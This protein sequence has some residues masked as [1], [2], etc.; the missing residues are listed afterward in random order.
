MNVETH[1]P[2]TRERLYS[3][4]R[5][6]V[7]AARDFTRTTLTTWN[8]R[9]PLDDVL[10]CVS[11]LTTNA[12]LYGVPPGRYFLLRLRPHGDAGVRVEVHDSGD[13]T[14]PIVPVPREDGGRGLLLVATLADKWGAERRH[15]GK[16]VWCEFG[17]HRR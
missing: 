16:V 14:L 5:R 10:L 15:P 13:G 11:E 1:L 4:S 6:S 17:T 7:P 3:R 8:T 2:T 9:A 12:L